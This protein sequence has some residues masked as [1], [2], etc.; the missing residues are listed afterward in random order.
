MNKHIT[1]VLFTLPAISLLCAVLIIPLGASILLSF[2]TDSGLGLGQ[3]IKLL[4]NDA[5]RYSF[6]ITFIFTFFSVA[7]HIVLGMISSLLLKTRLYLS[8]LWRIILLIPWIISPVICGVI[9]RW[10]LDPLYGIVNHWLTNLGLITQPILWLE[11]PFFAVVSV[12][13]AWIWTG[14]PFVMLIIL[15]GLQQIP[16]NLYEAAKVDGATSIQRF[17]H[18]TLPNLKLVLVVAALLDTIQCFRAFSSIYVMTQG[19][20]GDTTNVISIFI[21][22]HAFEYFEFEFASGAGVSMALVLMFLGYLYM[23]ALGEEV[24]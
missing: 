24:A 19:G 1:G 11:N 14:F 21:F 7:G 12:T 16:E 6:W 17:R 5:A 20:P 4:K 23:K 22:K 8:K 10:M 13:I 18:V 3:Y 9:W 2:E 15:A